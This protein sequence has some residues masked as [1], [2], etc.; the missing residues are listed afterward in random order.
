MVSCLILTAAWIAFAAASAF[1]EEPI[2]VIEDARTPVRIGILAKRGS[3]RCLEQWGPTA[4]Y[5]ASQIPD[6]SFSIIPLSFGEIYEAVDRENIDFFLVNPSVYIDIEQRFGARRIATLNNL[7]LDG[8]QQKAF[9][10]VIFC[11]ADR[12]DIRDVQDLEGKVFMAVDERSL[13]G[14]HMQW[15]EMMKH[16]IDPHRDFTALRFAG[17]HDGV[18]CAVRDGEVDAGSVRSDTLERMALEGKI[19]LDEFKLVIRHDGCDG[20]V[21]FMHSTPHY[22][23]W[24]LAKSSHI[25]DG[26]AK[27]VAIALMQM[28]ADSP[29]AQAAR[30]AGWTIPQNYHPVRECL[31]ALRL[32]PYEDY[33][34][35][36]LRDVL[37]QYAIWLLGI[38]LVTVLIVLF[39]V[40]MSRLKARL[41]QSE[42]AKEERERAHAFLQA[43]IDGLPESLMVIDRDHSVV[44]SNR[45][46]RKMCGSFKAD[47]DTLK[48]H[49][50]S[51]GRKSPCGGNNYPCPL[52]EVIATKGPVTVEHVRHNAQ[53]NVEST[54]LI[55]APIV[56]EQG[57]V[58]QVIESS[59]DITERKR[60]EQE[61]EELIARLE[62]QNAE[63]ERFAYTISHDL[64]SPLI[65]IKGYLGVLS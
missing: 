63:L 1:G 57:E 21:R 3:E 50:V 9:A 26:L 32:P 62:A 58:I 31:M 13:G 8:T 30:C 48:C 45:A 40:R 4:E 37:R 17:T 35:I 15:R 42:M 23:E 25:S 5:L 55:A 34:K 19:R 22:P 39:V 18:V 38:F 52:Q 47:S 54:E 43:V 7:Y 61:R 20:E 2:S 44:F 14:W 16:G 36:A 11:R 56:D 29:A 10:G 28:P 33:G 46:S 24:P 64:K 59:R 12:N 27:Q 53:G 41:E 60:A 6:H 51:H 65:T 49:E